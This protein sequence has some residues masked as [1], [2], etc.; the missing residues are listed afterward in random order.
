MRRELTL[1]FWGCMMTVVFSTAGFAQKYEVYPFLGGFWPMA[2]D[3][4]GDI[5]HQG[6]YGIRGGVHLTPEFQLEGSV[7]YL[8]HFE[9]RGT[10]PEVRAFTYDAIASWNFSA[11]EVFGPELSPYATVGVGALRTVFGDFDFDFGFNDTDTPSRPVG[12]I[13][14]GDNRRVVFNPNH[15]AAQPFIV[16]NEGATFFNFTYGGGVKGLN[17]WGP[18]GLR[19]EVRGRTMPNFYGESITAFEITGGVT[20]T[21]GEQ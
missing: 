20:I 16:M 13:G 1:L 4:I 14:T 2:N 11:R 17:L 7:G 15:T 6:F 10:D 18:V 9:L 12:V 5:K 19:G 3:S 21:W 8:N